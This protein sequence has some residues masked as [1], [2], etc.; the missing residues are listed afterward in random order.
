VASLT[1]WN[2][3]SPTPGCKVIKLTDDE[4]LS[5]LDLEGKSDK[6]AIIGKTWGGAPYNLNL[7]YLHGVT[8]FLGGRNTGKSHLAKKL[9]INL[10]DEGKKVIVFDIN[11]EWSAMRY[12]STSSFNAKA[13][14]EAM[15]EFK[16]SPKRTAH[17]PYCHKIV[18]GI[19]ASTWA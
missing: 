2:G 13:P 9:A 19:P 11:D 4:V 17:S 14:E 10:I 5:F 3:W 1:P 18:K 7:Y 16:A 12:C 6:I 8:V 15:K